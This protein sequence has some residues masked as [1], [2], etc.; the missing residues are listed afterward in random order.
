MSAITPPNE[1]LEQNLALELYLKLLLTE[2]SDD[3][4]EPVTLPDSVPAPAPALE[5]SQASKL[6]SKEPIETISSSIKPTINAKRLES[7]A[8]PMLTSIAVEK[9]PPLL[10][11]TLDLSLTEIVDVPKQEIILPIPIVEAAP[12]PPAEVKPIRPLSVMPD[13]SQGEFQALFFRVEHL[14]LATPLTELSRTVLFDRKPTKIPI[15]PSWFLGLLENQGTKIGILDTGQLI[16]GKLRGSNRNLVE[17]PFTNLLVSGDGKW[18]LACDEVLAISKIIP[19]KVRWRTF[20]QNRPWLIG[21]V[22][23]ELTA[24]VDITL[25]LPRK[26]SN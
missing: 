9:K 14:I 4:F 20:R 21:T 22:I 10:L 26:K 7:P 24:V 5:Q 3:D 8:T 1:I 15:Q 11:P 16:F 13:W 25:L 2:E 23:D 18:G 19:D 17:R 6:T 12:I